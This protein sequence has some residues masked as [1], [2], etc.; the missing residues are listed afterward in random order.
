MSCNV[1]SPEEPRSN[2]ARLMADILSPYSSNGRRLIES[3]HDLPAIVPSTN[4]VSAVLSAT[5]IFTLM[6]KSPSVSSV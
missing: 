1:Y 4:S 6:T 2:G 3:P 5:V